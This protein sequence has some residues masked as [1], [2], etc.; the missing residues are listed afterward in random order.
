MPRTGAAS[1]TRGRERLFGGVGVAAGELRLDQVGRRGRPVHGQD[2]GQAGA[3][4]R[5]EHLLPTPLRVAGGDQ[6]GTEAPAGLAGG[7]EIRPGA[8]LGRVAGVAQGRG[9]VTGREPR[10]RERALRPQQDPGAA[11]EA[12]ALDAF[13]AGRRRVGDP[14][15]LDQ[16][17]HRLDREHH[18]H[19]LAA[20][21]LCELG[22]APEVGE[23][24]VQLSEPAA[25]T[26]LHPERR[27]ARLKLRRAEPLERGARLVQPARRLLADPP[28]KRLRAP[29]RPGRRS[30]TPD[31]RSRGRRRARRR[32][33]RAPR[34][35]RRPTTRSGRARVAAG[36]DPGMAQ[37]AARRAPHT[38]GGAR[39]RDRRATTPGW[40][41]RS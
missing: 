29:R 25:R 21:P 20:G 5:V 24:R 33:G 14:A 35:D 16:R 8:R 26:T 19:A 3:A 31:R 32:S 4:K 41:A 18:Q 2:A 37:P 36:R 27:E 9:D 39:L 11:G 34:R 28:P 17:R 38:G 15:E 10:R 40:P 1:G 7:V 12:R 23:R 30:R 6:R 22:T 13:L